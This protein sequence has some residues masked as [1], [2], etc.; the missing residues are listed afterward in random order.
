VDIEDNVHMLLEGTVAEMILK[1]DPTIYRKHIWYNRHGKPMLYVQLKK[2]LYG[3]LQAG[4]LFWKLLSEKLHEWGFTLNSY[5]KCV[6]NK[7][8]EGKQCTMTWHVDDLKISHASKDVVEDIIKKLKNKFGQEI[9]LTTCRGKLLEY[10]GMKIDYRQKGKLKFSMYKYIEKMLKELPASME[11]L[12]TTPA[13][14][15]LF[16]TDPG[17]K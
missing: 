5:D 7:N 9:P 14:S 2:A 15:Y 1:L 6:A 13:S 4:L 17:C 11:G 16:N 3:T 8:I 10:L 12:V